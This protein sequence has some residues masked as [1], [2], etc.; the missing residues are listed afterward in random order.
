MMIPFLKEGR[1]L[2]GRFNEGLLEETWFH[3]EISCDEAEARLALAKAGS[4]LVRNVGILY[5]FSFVQ[6]KTG[7]KHVKV[8]SNRKHSLLIE[9]LELKTEYQ[10]IKYILRLRCK[11]FLHPVDRPQDMLPTD[12][13][14]LE[15]NSN[16]DSNSLFKCSYCEIFVTSRE[17]LN[18]HKI[19]H[20]L[21][22]CEICK[23][24]FPTTHHARHKSKCDPN[25]LLKCRRCSEFRTE[26][27]SH[28]DDHKT[29]CQAK[30]KCSTCEKLFR[31]E[32]ALRKHEI[33]SHKKRVLCALCDKTFSNDSI[34]YMHQVNIHED[35]IKSKNK[36][37]HLCPKCDYKTSHKKFLRKHLNIEHPQ[38][39]YQ[40]DECSFSTSNKPKFKTHKTHTHPLSHQKEISLK[41]R[42]RKNVVVIGF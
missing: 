1:T 40:C 30:F 26:S 42:R 39:K 29:I 16:N 7:I 27:R 12:P 24:M 36:D 4:F 3:G 25:F 28:M 35:I 15:N 21:M 34:L 32:K 31:S 17:N 41:Q 14:S 19:T 13:K 38:H 9:N 37:K 20:G 11:F 23:T 18:K 22:Y 33:K 8:P 5:I 6:N 2:D 10:V